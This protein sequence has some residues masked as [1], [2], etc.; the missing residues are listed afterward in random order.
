MFASSR[1]P[2]TLLPLLFFLSLASCGGGSPAQPT[3]DWIELMSILPAESSTF[4]AGERVTFTATVDCTVATSDGGSVA[5][6]VQAPDV[7]N[8]PA[9]TASLSKGTR[10]VTL[11]S[12]VT[13][14]ASGTA[15][16]VFIPLW[17][18]ESNTTAMMKRV[19]YSVR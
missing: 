6:V 12:T 5:L 8:Q 17:V 10:T 18:N 14:P 16:T 4:A 9:P 3:R 15:V 13:M 1:R 19:S 7:L 2:S 11:T